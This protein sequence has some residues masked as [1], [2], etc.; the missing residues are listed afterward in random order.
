M[1]FIDDMV[2]DAAVSVTPSLS[3]KATVH[4]I[5]S[6]SDVSDHVILAPDR[7]TIRGIVSSTPMGNVLDFRNGITDPVG[8]IREKFNKLHAAR[9]AI[10]IFVEGYPL[11]TDM[12]LEGLSDPSSAAVGESM[13]FSARF[14]RIVRVEVNAI[15]VEV[16]V[17]LP[18]NKRRKP[19]GAQAGTQAGT[20]A[21]D[22]KTPKAMQR[23]KAAI[24]EAQ[25]NVT[26]ITSGRKT[27]TTAGLH[28]DLT[29]GLADVLQGSL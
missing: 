12:I 8:D 13:Q 5:A 26:R 9:K 27:G 2:I 19:K 24:E 23:S 3:A 29:D 7:L 21:A 25:N 22:A 17:D 16:R 15:D 11:F 20:T 10:N 28:D 18:R 4:P 6:G 1:I 14:V